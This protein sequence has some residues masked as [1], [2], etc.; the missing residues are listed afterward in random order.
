[1]D[2]PLRTE[3]HA[4]LLI[5]RF[6]RKNTEPGRGVGKRPGMPQPPGSFGAS[7]VLSERVMKIQTWQC[8][9]LGERSRGRRKSGVV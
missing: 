1:M 3:P 9:C 8:S 4:S 2:R 5:L 6:F 7:V